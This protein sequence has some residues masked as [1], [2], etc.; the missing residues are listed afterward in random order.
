MLGE[1]YTHCNALQ[2]TTEEISTNFNYY[3][4]LQRAYKTTIKYNKITDKLSLP[5]CN[6]FFFILTLFLSVGASLAPTHTT[7]APQQ[8]RRLWCV[9]LIL[10]YYQVLL[11]EQSDSWH[12]QQ[13]YKS[14]VQVTRRRAPRKLG[15]P[16]QWPPPHLK[17]QAESLR[18]ILLTLFSS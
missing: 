5:R 11:P 9:R 17:K 7:G 12:Y 6:Y 3:S 10:K 16:G 14:H 2:I 4:L 1:I 18:D 13:R 8:S 15:T